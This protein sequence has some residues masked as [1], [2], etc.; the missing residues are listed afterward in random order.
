MCQRREGGIKNR[1]E[2][3]IGATLSGM[4]Y[5]V[6]IDE[7]GRG[8]LAGPVA[9]G[10]VAVPQN[11]RARKALKKVFPKIK[12][13]KQLSEK[14]RDVWFAE[15]KRL[16]KVGHLSWA[17]SFSSAKLIDEEGITRAVARATARTL[18][19]LALHPPHALLLLDGGLKA[20]AEYAR[21]KTI[22]RGDATHIEIALASVCAKVLRDRK[23][24][25]YA[26]LY[27]FYAFEKHKGY[28]T[29]KHIRAI[30]KYGL[31]KVHRASFCQR[32]G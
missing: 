1:E 4:K 19:K 18:K 29:A 5:I 14:Q 21:Q 24:K 11:I 7:A 10:G 28:G 30:R 15:I 8:P 32:I 12:D 26:K 20:P 9:V 16:A 6:G 17:V 2:D 3:F 27:S 25:Q 22:V 13:S 23:M 31:S